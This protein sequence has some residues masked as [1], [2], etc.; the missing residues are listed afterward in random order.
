MLVVSAWIESNAVTK[1]LQNALLSEHFLSFSLLA[2]L[3]PI[4]NNGSFR[5]IT[6]LPLPQVAARA[7]TK[8]TCLCGSL[9]P[10]RVLPASLTRKNPLTWLSDPL[11]IVVNPGWGGPTD[12]IEVDSCWTWT[13]L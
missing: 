3:S 5:K 6:L 1:Y 12:F 8:P 4:A 11:D 10:K 9:W 7:H 13:N 2:A